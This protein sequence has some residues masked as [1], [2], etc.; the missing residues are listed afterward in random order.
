MKSFHLSFF[1]FFNAPL[2]L[3]PIIAII[4]VYNKQGLLDLAKGLIK[5]DI[6]LLASGGTAKRKSYY[7]HYAQFDPVLKS[8]CHGI[9][10]SIIP[11]WSFST[12]HV[13]L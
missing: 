3:D 10:S 5:H 4:S 1:E 12:I 7:F 6:R 8:I 11:S 2:T 13:R 9:I